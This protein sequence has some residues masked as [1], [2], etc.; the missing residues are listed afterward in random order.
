LFNLTLLYHVWPDFYQRFSSASETHVSRILELFF[1]STVSTPTQP[2]SVVDVVPNVMP[3]LKD[4]VEDKDLSYF[5][6]TVFKEYPYS[7]DSFAHQ[8]TNGFIGLRKVGLP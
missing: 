5:L 7:K 3:F 8:L 1:L 4:Y 6:T 2:A